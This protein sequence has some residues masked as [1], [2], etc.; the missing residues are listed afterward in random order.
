MAVRSRRRTS[1]TGRELSVDRCALLLH[2]PD[3]AEAFT[4]CQYPFLSVFNKF[5]STV[6]FAEIDKKPV[7]L[8]NWLEKDN[9]F[10][11]KHDTA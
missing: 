10:R 7:F 8:P 9:I 4:P 1:A 2:L 6:D 11:P 3:H 5:R